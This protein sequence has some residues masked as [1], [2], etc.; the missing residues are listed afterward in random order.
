MAQ[1][2]TFLH[3]Y[4]PAATIETQ[5]MEIK[6]KCSNFGDFRQKMHDH[7]GICLQTTKIKVE[8]YKENKAIEIKLN[9]IH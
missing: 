2:N 9:V 8:K 6:A 5:P 4:T 3:F 1:K 7:A